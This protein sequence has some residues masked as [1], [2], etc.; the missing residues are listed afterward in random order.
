[1]PDESLHASTKSSPVPWVCDRRREVRWRCQLQSQSRALGTKVDEWAPGYA[2]N[3]STSGIALVVS[4][5]VT[6]GLIL[7][8]SLPG[9]QGGFLPARLVR[10]RRVKCQ[11][12]GKWLAGCTFVRRLTKEELD[13]LLGQQASSS[14]TES[15]VQDSQE[16]RLRA[17][18]HRVVGG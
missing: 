16:A 1:M 12:E 2:C 13:S 4:F 11:A 5:H 14:P 17:V 18:V 15:K 7:E 9:A 6:R 10:V 3:L 8:V